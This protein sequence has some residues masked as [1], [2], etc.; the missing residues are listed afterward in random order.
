METERLCISGVGVPVV[1]DAF[2]LMLQTVF[3][4]EKSI[5]WLLFQI[6][7]VRHN[8]ADDLSNLIEAEKRFPFSDLNRVSKTDEECKDNNETKG[9]SVEDA[10]NVG[11]EDSDDD[12][13]D[14][15]EDSS[16]EDDE[17][18][19]DEGDVDSDSDDDNG[20]SDDDDDD[21]DDDDDD[22]D[23]DDDDDDDDDEDEDNQP[24]FKKTK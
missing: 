7:S 19:D 24:P 12:N 4:A 20:E 3:I 18:D 21:E 1:E 5:C 22:D 8:D 16:G 6:G 2:S 15:D 13:D 10:D 14:D 9:D 23:E 17:D 11:D